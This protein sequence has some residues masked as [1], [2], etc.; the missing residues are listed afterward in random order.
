MVGDARS[1]ELG[2]RFDLVLAAMQFLQLLSGRE[3]RIAALRCCRAHLAD[4]G[5]FAAALLDL[6]GESTNDDYTA[7]PPDMSE[8]GGWVW[9]SQAVEVR[10]LEGGAALSL[11]RHRRAVSPRGELAETE[12]SVRLEMVSC[13]E[14]EEEL[15]AAGITPT[16]RQQIRPTRDHVGSVV[17]FGDAGHG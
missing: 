12:D 16:R 15:W 2:R 3:E 13:D 8:T 5:V 7:P 14:L 1:F 17:V 9:S 11:D 6:S 4:R 10:L